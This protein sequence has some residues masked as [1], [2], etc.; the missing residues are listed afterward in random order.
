[1]IVRTALRSASLALLTA[2]LW[3]CASSGPDVVMIHPETGVQRRC[4]TINTTLSRPNPWY[5]LAAIP[6]H[7]VGQGQSLGEQERC[8]EQ[9]KRE[10]FVV[11][12]R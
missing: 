1:M 5:G 4:M 8:V 9:A 6:A 7:A 11:R 2:S 10:G 3:G 12:E